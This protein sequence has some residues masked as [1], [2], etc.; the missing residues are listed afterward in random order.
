MITTSFIGSA[1]CARCPHSNGKAA[2]RKKVR[3]LLKDDEQKLSEYPLSVQDR[4]KDDTGFRHKLM[5]NPSALYSHCD[6]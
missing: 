3:Q 5:C 1:V 2:G 6:K 4:H